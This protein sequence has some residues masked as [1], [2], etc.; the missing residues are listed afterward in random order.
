V[1]KPFG[2]D[3]LLARVR[4]ALRRSAAETETTALEAPKSSERP[5]AER[6]AAVVS[7]PS[8]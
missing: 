4:A 5:V 3:Q 1:T 6:P 7:R 8:R 2:I